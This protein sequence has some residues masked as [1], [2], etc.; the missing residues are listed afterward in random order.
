[1]R[2]YNVQIVA[3]RNG[4]EIRFV[5]VIAFPLQST[6]RSGCVTEG[7]REAG[8]IEQARIKYPELTDIRADWSR[9]V[10]DDEFDRTNAR[11]QYIRLPG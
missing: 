8:A 7:A 4:Q 2:A 10:S 6:D 9:H 1:M 3:M 11:P 5:E